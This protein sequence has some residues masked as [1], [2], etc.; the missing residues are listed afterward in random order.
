MEGREGG[1]TYVK[2]SKRT[3]GEVKGKREEEREER[4]EET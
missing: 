3:A 1:E 4:E 2:A